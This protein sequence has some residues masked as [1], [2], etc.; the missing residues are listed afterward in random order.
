[1]HRV[2]NVK[3]IT[4]IFIHKLCPISLCLF[5]LMNSHMVLLFLMLYSNYDVK[6]IHVTNVRLIDLFYSCAMMD[7]CYNIHIMII[8]Y[9]V[10]YSFLC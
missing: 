3:F 8:V 1:M 5:P 6:I 4:T 7:A 2:K 10:V 9:H